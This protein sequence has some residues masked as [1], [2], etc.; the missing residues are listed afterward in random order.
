MATVQQR[1][2]AGT[3]AAMF[4]ISIIA[5]T[6][7]VIV[8]M[9]QE[10]KQKDAAATA[11]TAQQKP[12]EG[13][14]QGTKLSGF[15]PVASVAELQTVDLQPGTGKEITSAEDTVTADYTGALAK[16]GTIFQ[17]S[18]DSGQPF[19]TQLNGV[20]EGWQKGMIGMKEGGKRRLVI[21]AAQAYGPQ[22]QGGI[23][24]NSDLVFD[25][26]LHKVGK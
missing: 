11:Q 10:N 3:G 19:T 26:T 9:V 1:I 15:K 22:E 4:F 14:L 13:Q 12:K 8:T 23:P 21:P 2:I 18:L 20:I 17:S 7:V 6:V 5:L 16:D 24:A 25:I